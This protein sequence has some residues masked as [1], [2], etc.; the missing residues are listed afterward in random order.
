[1]NF[2]SKFLNKT[3]KKETSSVDNTYV[4]ILISLNK[5][6][7]ID[8][9]VFIDCDYKKT[10]LSLVDYTLL[11]SK[12][13]NF[14]SD[15]IK[16]QIIDILQYQIKTTQNELFIKGLISLLK[17]NNGFSKDNNIDDLYIKPSQVFTKHIH[18]HQ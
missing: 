7:E 14:D 10:Q 11:C 12:F 2:L 1:M 6:F 15:K 3:K 4:D 9:S 17:N 18:E 16:T 13:L 8:L 5:N